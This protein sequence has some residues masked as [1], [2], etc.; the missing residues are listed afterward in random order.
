MRSLLTV[1]TGTLLTIGLAF[2]FT[3][4]IGWKLAGSEIVARM[5]PSLLDLGVAV[6][7]GAA[8]AFAYTRPGVS[9]AL[10]GIAIAVALVPPLCTVGIVMA[11]GQEASAEVGLALD[12]FSARGP[13]L[14]Y[15]TNIIGIVFAGSLVFFWR[16]YRRRLLAMLA[17]ALT[18]GSLIIVVPPL[19]IGMDNLLIRNQVHRSLTVESR[20]LLPAK[21]DF[22]FTNLSVRIRQ[23]TVFVRGD[24]VA[25]PGLFTQELINA[26]RDKLSE[27]VTMPV[28]LEF[29]IIPEMILRSMEEANV[30][31]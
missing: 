3:E 31:G 27:M 16:Y 7:A 22:R 5:K 25:S 8:A 17:L 21:H 10:A 29:G 1:V 11:L 4:A 18:I 6:A 15:L 30:D 14:L 9:S 2:V 23:G 12:S 26:L 20:A 28:I 24:I 13:F 19:G